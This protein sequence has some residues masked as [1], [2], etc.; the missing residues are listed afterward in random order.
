MT[1]SN[2]DAAMFGWRRKW[3]PEMSVS[4]HQKHG[5]DLLGYAPVN[6]SQIFL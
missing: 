1:Q 2:Q 5:W 3:T 4:H 6:I